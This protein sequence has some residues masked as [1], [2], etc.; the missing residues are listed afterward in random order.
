MSSDLLEAEQKGEGGGGYEWGS[1]WNHLVGGVW[2]ERQEMQSRLRQGS[3]KGGNW[4]VR[5]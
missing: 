3:V 1:E 4:Q 2:S 5:R